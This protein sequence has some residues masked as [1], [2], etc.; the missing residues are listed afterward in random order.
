MAPVTSTEHA[1]GLNV[2]VPE[3]YEPL[4]ILGQGAMGVVYKARDRDLDRIV[5]IKTIHPNSVASGHDVNAIATRLSQEAMAAARLGH[6][7]IVAVYDVG[8]VADTP[9]I[10]MEYFTGRT[11]AEMLEA[12]ALPPARA[13]DV[14]LQV[15]RA[16]EYA[17]AQ[18][19]V[20]RDIKP[21]NIM[22]DARGHAKLT[23]FGVARLVD[24]PANETPVMVGTPA[25]MSPEQA[26][27]GAADARSDV[28]ALGAVLYE[29]LTGAKAF[30]GDD[31]T[32]VLDDV[33][34]T[35]PVPPRERNFVVSPALDGVV[36]RAMEKDPDDRYRD[37][38]ALGE[39]LMQ[40]APR[41]SGVGAALSFARG[42]S[43]VLVGGAILVG[44]GAGVFVTTVVGRVATQPAPI[45]VAPPAPV[46]VAPSA[47]AVEDRRRLT[48]PH[49]APGRVMTAQP[50]ETAGAPVTTP[51]PADEPS[52]RATEREVPIEPRQPARWGC[53]SV[54]AVPFASVFVDGKPVGETP[55]A[56]VRVRQGQR[57]L[58]FEWNGTRSPDQIVIV[59]K[60]HTAEN[61]LRASYDFRT[62]R[63]RSSNE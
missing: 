48:E 62:R 44:I 18:G 55:Q 40:A 50:A 7:G 58:Q 41:G 51:P 57:R 31:F 47:P 22:V 56:C 53:V 16:L 42:W 49:E 61:P 39:A 5:A 37:A 23:D 34:H 59:S 1:I 26:R 36:R 19:V 21:T 2:R 14:A 27:G 60:E 63:F 45:V 33:Q 54:N 15:C 10:V 29:T 4:E 52:T 25:Y 12:G 9:Y 38:A 13:V 30:P 43:A 35:E 17:H 46:A 28:F 32:A 24:K 3:R 6:P 20:H 8:R 11:L